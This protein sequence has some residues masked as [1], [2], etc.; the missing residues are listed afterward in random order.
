M[1]MEEYKNL[2]T[3]INIL[4]ELE[5]NPEISQKILSEKV[6]ISVGLIN[7]FIK[8]LT[9]KGFLKIKR[10]NGKSLAY[11]L[12]PK[13]IKEKTRLIKEYFQYSIS[14][15]QRARNIL[16]KIFFELKNDGINSVIIYTTP[17]WAEISYLISKN[18]NFEIYGFI[19]SDKNI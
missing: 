4:Q 7:L 18:L 6:G 5:N 17:E 8:R 2:D 14:H 9:K 1:V 3:S 16:K 13:G 10:L 19:I 12:T 11:L 15:Y